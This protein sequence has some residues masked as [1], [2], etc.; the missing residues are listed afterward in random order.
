M[1]LKRI[2]LIVSLVSVLSI[3]AMAL[4]SAQSASAIRVNQVSTLET[5]NGVNLKIYFNVF[6]PKTGAPILDAEPSSAQVTLLFTN[7][8]SQGQV[9]KTGYSHLHHPGFGFKWKHG[10]DGCRQAQTSSQAGA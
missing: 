10:R 5:Q 2:A 3:P 9:K 7:L 4:V 6:D 1:T 8:V